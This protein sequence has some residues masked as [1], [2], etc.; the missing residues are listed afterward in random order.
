MVNITL[1]TATED[2]KMIADT[3]TSTMSDYIIQQSNSDFL[4]K[5]Q[6]MLMKKLVCE[7]HLKKR[8]SSE[9][10]NTFTQGFVGYLGNELHGNQQMK[11]KL[12][13]FASQ[14][15]TI[16][17]FQVK[18][19]EIEKL[20][21]MSRIFTLT[22]KIGG[23]IYLQS[24]YILDASGNEI[25]SN[26]GEIM[27]TDIDINLPVVNINE[28]ASSTVENQGRRKATLEKLQANQIPYAV[29]MP[30]L[31]DSKQVNIKSVDEIARR[32]AVL[33]ILIQFV[34]EVLDDTE[35]KNIKTSRRISEVYL[36][37]FGVKNNLTPAEELFLQQDSY[38]QQQL[39]DKMW[40]YEAAWLLLWSIHV[41]DDLKE[42]TEICD[43]ESLLN[44][45]TSYTTVSELMDDAEMREPIK[46]LQRM[47]ENYLYHWA[48]V[49]ARMMGEIAPAGLDEGVVMERQRAFNWLTQ[50][51][52]EP[53]DEVTM[54][55]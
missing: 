48:T 54:N 35:Q 52:N 24:G 5:K 3:I 13:Y 17:S 34:R 26:E 4:I 22:E 31:P 12:V 55:T 15:K 11:G 29:E 33:L 6:R 10:A 50:L 2:E 30:L 40:L 28:F 9:D 19:S 43:V 47:D 38:D 20:N 51:Q 21:F 41:I 36:N 27:V 32:A 7:I 39:I 44:L 53:W 42:P 25:V 14:V 16:I 8:Q 23:V 37:R 18:E 46:I 49:H 1:Y 45:L